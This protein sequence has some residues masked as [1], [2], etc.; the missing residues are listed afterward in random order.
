M[1]PRAE[2]AS[3][4]SAAARRASGGTG[5][6]ASAGVG[7][8]AGAGAAAPSAAAAAA[9][10]AAERAVEAERLRQLVRHLAQRSSFSVAQ[11]RALHQLW[12]RDVEPYKQAAS[13]EQRFPVAALDH[14][15][16]R[17]RAE[18]GAEY[19]RTARDFCAQVLPTDREHPFALFEGDAAAVA[20][21]L[22]RECDALSFD[23]YIAVLEQ[24]AKGGRAKVEDRL[25]FL[26]QSVD[27][28]ADGAISLA[29]LM[30]L[31]GGHCA[32]RQG[33]QEALYTWVKKNF[34][35][36]D[37]DKSGSLDFFECLT[38]LRKHPSILHDVTLNVDVLIKSLGT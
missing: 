28:D 30:E 35:A 9:A 4:K 2:R 33:Q 38:I 14:A 5:T 13:L 27:R 19:A 34:Q 12:T 37:T 8:G 18:L 24:L 15:G 3:A 7:A 10:A 11:I 22:D 32:G 16:E 29:E 31:L 20:R 21:R 23:D 17:R 6:G 25:L 36:A 26:F 1:A